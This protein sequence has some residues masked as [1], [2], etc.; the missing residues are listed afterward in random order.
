MRH[1]RRLSKDHA[2]IRRDIAD[3]L[4]HSVRC[5]ICRLAHLLWIERCKVDL[6][7]ILTY[8]FRNYRLVFSIQY[9]NMRLK[10]MVGN[11]A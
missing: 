5:R 9:L 6:V 8:V 4:C 3:L 10:L 11:P 1:L 2:I 7:L